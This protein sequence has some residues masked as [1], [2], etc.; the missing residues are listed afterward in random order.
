MVHAY[1]LIGRE[2]VDVD[3]RG[4]VRAGHGE[5]LIEVVAARL[6]AGLARGSASPA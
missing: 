4:I 5:R 2:I 6:S 3:Q 1:W